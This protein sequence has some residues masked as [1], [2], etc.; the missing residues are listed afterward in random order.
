[1]AGRRRRIVRRSPASA[2]S[3]QI[4]QVLSTAR[5]QTVAARIGAAKPADLSPSSSNDRAGEGDHASVRLEAGV[6][7]ARVVGEA[8]QDRGVGFA[9]VNA[10][11][12]RGTW[13]STYWESFRS[14][15]QPRER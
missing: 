2:R 10:R 5:R 4:D 9:L 12:S 3:H 13:V 8:R 7:D 15:L 11:P 1:L 6:S 14:S